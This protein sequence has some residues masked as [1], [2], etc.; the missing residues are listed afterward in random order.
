ME[1]KAGLANCVHD[2]LDVA[3]MI[4]IIL[5]IDEDV[6]DEHNAVALVYVLNQQVCH[7]AHRTRLGHWQHQKA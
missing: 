1:A 2:C 5:G 4:L 7:Q 6:V 3:F